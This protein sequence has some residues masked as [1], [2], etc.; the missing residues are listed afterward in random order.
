MSDAEA[1]VN[2]MLDDFV[3]MIRTRDRSL[4]DRLCGEGGFRLI[5]SEADEICRT[6]AEVE[7]KLSAVFGSAATLVLEFPVRDVTVVGP[8]AWIFAEGTLTRVEPDGVSTS[9][10]YLADC[11]F[12]RT[13]TGWRWRQFFGSEPA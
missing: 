6:R 11:I 4:V 13:A 9:R 12:E 10:V 5:G 1:A 3:E 8:V 7:A 2:A